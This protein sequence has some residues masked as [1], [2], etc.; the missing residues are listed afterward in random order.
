[1]IGGPAPAGWRLEV[2][3]TLTS[4]SDH[5]IA[6]AEEGEAARLAV[7]ARH[8]S[9]GRGSRGRQWQE[10]GH[11]LALS[12]LLRPVISDVA[13]AVFMAALALRDAL[14]PFVP[15]PWQLL[16]KWPNDVLLVPPD[17]SP[18]KLGGILIERGVSAGA[19]DWMVIGFGANLAGVPPS[20]R[21]TAA[22]LAEAGAIAPPAETV[23]GLVLDAFDRWRI[24]HAEHGFETIRSAWL[25]RAHKAGTR[26]SVRGARDL[27]GGFAGLTDRGALILDTGTGLAE[28]STGAV[29]LA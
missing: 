26:M 2:Y 3:E 23:A 17:A 25:A 18:R 13:S 15:K 29:L 21:E 5:V 27:A 4:T 11:G 12:V 19:G 22:C 7:M 6:R 16:L 28:V 1:M 14:E 20:L 9:A 8:Q 10:P 24:E